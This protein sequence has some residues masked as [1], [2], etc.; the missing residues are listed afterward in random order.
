MENRNA[1]SAAAPVS[2]GTHRTQL[3]YRQGAS[4]GE[5]ATAKDP[6]IHESAHSFISKGLFAYSGPRARAANAIVDVSWIALASSTNAARRSSATSSAGGTS[7][8]TS[9]Y[10][11][12][13]RI[14]HARLYAEGQSMRFD[15]QVREFRTIGSW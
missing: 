1:G 5:E 10:A 4:P 6:A 3:P 9:L 2:E 12:A 14:T 11:A 13:A 15:I 8:L 7:D